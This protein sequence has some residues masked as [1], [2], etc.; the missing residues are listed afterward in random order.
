MMCQ[1]HLEPGHTPRILLADDDRELRSLLGTTLRRAGY[2]VIEAGDGIEVVN[3]LYAD[4]SAEWM[5]PLDAIVSDLCMPGLTGLEAL[6]C[7]RDDDH[8][9]P[10]ILM[11]AFGTADVRAQARRL[12]AT[13]VLMKPFLPGELRLLLN[14]LL[15]H[16]QPVR[17]G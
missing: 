14:L 16:H 10:F 13:A 8:R 4:G 17:S 6:T 5:P 12:G 3:F 9:L 2:E 11:T 7:L 15:G 1:R